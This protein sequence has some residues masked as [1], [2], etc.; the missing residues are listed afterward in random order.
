MAYLLAADIGGTKTLIQLS[1]VAGDVIASERYV[2]ADYQSFEQI[3]SAFLASLDRQYQIGVA[4]L[5]IAGPVSGANAKVTN[6]PWEI[7]ADDV[8]TAFDF[9][10]VILCND[11][12]AIGYGI[13][14]LEEK[15][16]LTLHAGKPASGPRALIGAGT[17]LGQAYLVE[18]S[19]AWQVIATEGG[20]TD[21][22]PT[23]RTQ[24]RLLEQLFDRFGHVSYERLVSGSG[25]EAIYHF[26]RD[27][28]QY[29]EDPDCRLAMVKA[30]AANV[31]SEFAHKGE[32]LAKEAMALFFSIYGAQAGNLAL[33]VMPKAGLYIAGGIAAKNLHQLEQSDFMQAFLNKGR[34][35]TLLENIPV[36]VILQAEVG[37]NGARLLAAKAMYN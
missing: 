22:A 20:H 23:D 6:L 28:R 33:T 5:A 10:K 25:L 18:Q 2:S 27:Y 29:E 21:F 12:E 34:M 16:L 32:P 37:L 30:D 35:Q 17:G 14:A 24:V 9:G 31:I 7:Q 11:F 3:L 15:D 8:A 36:K 19:G 1:A 4:C 13:E 26:L